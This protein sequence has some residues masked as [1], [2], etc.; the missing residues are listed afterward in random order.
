V[1]GSLRCRVCA[2]AVTDAYGN[3]ERRAAQALH[4]LN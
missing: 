4:D 1:A 3:I 2:V